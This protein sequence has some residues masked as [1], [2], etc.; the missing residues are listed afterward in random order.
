MSSLY[1]V[2][3][4]TGSPTQ[5]ETEKVTQIWQGSLFNANIELQRL[6]LLNF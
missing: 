5:A 4:I 1:N 3:Y 6:V 2:L